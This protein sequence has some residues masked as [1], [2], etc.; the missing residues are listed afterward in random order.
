MPAD[1]CVLLK[2]YRGMTA[3]LFARFVPIFTAAGRD[4]NTTLADGTT[5]LDH[6]SEHRRS[7]EYIDALVEAGA[8]KSTG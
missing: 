5:I 4:L 2:A 6:I 1:Y 8:T 3:E 7:G